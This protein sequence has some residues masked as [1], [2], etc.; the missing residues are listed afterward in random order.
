M[1]KKITPLFFDLALLIATPAMANT[2][3]APTQPSTIA[4]SN[5]DWLEVL[6]RFGGSTG[7]GPNTYFKRILG[8]G[9]DTGEGPST[10]FMA[11]GKSSGYTATDDLWQFWLDVA[12]S[13]TPW[14]LKILGYGGDTGDG[15]NPY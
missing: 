8:Y 9:G 4:A 5:V 1:I 11:D 13:D 10:F 12:T 7:D 14:Q 6:L 15:P 3:T 2:M